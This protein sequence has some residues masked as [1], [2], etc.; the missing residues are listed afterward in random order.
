MT[1]ATWFADTEA[2]KVFSTAQLQS[3]SFG[4]SERKSEVGRISETGNEPSIVPK[5]RHLQRK[6][7]KSKEHLYTKRMDSKNVATAIPLI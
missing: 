1:V 4:D 3:L 7:V 2:T 6:N 5:T